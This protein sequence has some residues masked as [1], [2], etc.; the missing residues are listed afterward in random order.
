MTTTTLLQPALTPPPQRTALLNALTVDVEDYYHVSGFEGI[1]SRDDWDRFPSRIEFSTNTILDI[2][3]S[4][5]VRA[6]FYVLG[7]VAERYPK[8]VRSIRAAGHE[9]GSHSYWH[10]L[11]YTQT[12]DEFRADLRRSCRVLEDA[13]GEAVTTYRAPSFSIT[14][15]APWAL[16]VLIAEGI[17]TDSSVFP[18]HHDRYGWA[19]APLTPCRVVRP[20]GSLLEFPMPIRRVLGYPLAVGGG[21][22]LR[23]YPYA[24]TRHALKAINAEGLPFCSYL[25][26]WE[27]DVA[28]PRMRPGLLRRF[29]HYVNLHR[30][31]ERLERLCAD[32]RFG[33][34]SEVFASLDGRLPTWNLAD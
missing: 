23:L 9:V 32:F 10:R 14:P 4:C 28:Q 12:P 34:V 7:W 6:T 5:G 21:G 3:H 25:H 1:V 16:D 8:L 15:R 2:L 24:L 17:R 13:L 29:R 11:V 20:E 18:T 26:P 27:V 31:R 22:Y 19:G 30:T 33:T